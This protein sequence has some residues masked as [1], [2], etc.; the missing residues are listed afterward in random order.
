MR[1]TIRGFP[2]T[3]LLL[4]AALCLMACGS[5]KVA[6]TSKS[7]AMTEVVQEVASAVIQAETAHA[8]QHS[9]L[10]QVETQQTTTKSEDM[11]VVPAQTS[12]LT[13]PTQNLLDLPEGA[14]Y[15]ASEGRSSVEAKRQGDNIVITGN[16]DSVAR[17]S[18]RFEQ[19]VFRQCSTIDSLRN[20]ILDQQKL[21]DEYEALEKARSGTTEQ[22]EQT[23]KKPSNW[24][25]WLLGGVVLGVALCI[26]VRILWNRTR[27]GSI[28]KTLINKVTKLWQK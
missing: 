19:T 13:V 23:V 1:K 3:L 27:L 11:E 14:S 8:E 24:H 6:T 25:K 20:V 2:L 28:I 22:V 18:W 15:N 17:R 5:T 21:I 9:V 10:H 7:E 12:S 4:L 16:C 26:A